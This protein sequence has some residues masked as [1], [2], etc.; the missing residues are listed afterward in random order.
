MHKNLV[1]TTLALATLSLTACAGVKT[2][3]STE[4]RADIGQGFA[5]HSREL[6]ACY[7]RSGLKTKVSLSLRLDVNKDKDKNG[8]WNAVSVQGESTSDVA[9]MLL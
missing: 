2:R 8:G 6:R 1:T 4:W 5:N 3:T 7:D 9:P